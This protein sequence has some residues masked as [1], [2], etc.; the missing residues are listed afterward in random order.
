[1]LASTVFAYSA[2]L[3]RFLTFG[4]EAVLAGTTSVNEYAIGMDVF[5]R[6]GNF[7]PRLD[8]IVRVHA[9]RLRSKLVQYYETEGAGDPISIQLPLRSYIPVFQPKEPQTLQIRQL[10][11]SRVDP[12]GHGS[13]VVFPFTNLN[14]NVRDDDFAEGLT[15]EVT[16]SLACLRNWRIIS[17][18]G[19]DSRPDV[20]DIGRHL[21]SE[22][23]LWGTLRRAENTFRISVELI[24]TKDATV[25][26]SDM[27]ECEA[28]GT[29]LTQQ[30]IA[31]AVAQ[32][33]GPGVG[34]VAHQCV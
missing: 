14:S 10:A 1:M 30:K 13:I 11:P 6:D 31:Q 8:P 21:H 7:D 18:T 16:H 26:G 22:A 17:W 33:L 2:R 19:Q 12:D 28:T 24:C 9:R 25:L 32:A 34:R 3:S 29:V 20:C 5:E 23:V 4:V 27:Y 15:R